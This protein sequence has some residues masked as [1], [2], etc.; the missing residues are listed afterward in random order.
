MK[1]IIS[2]FGPLHLVK[3]AVVLSK[4]VDV[5]VIQGYIPNRWNKW[6]LHLLSRILKRDMIKAF[7]K[8]TPATLDGNNYSVFF[9]EL[10]RFFVHYLGIE[11]KLKLGY[12]THVMYGFFSRR[13]INKSEIFHVRSGSGLGG[14]IDKARRLGM[15]VIVDH[16][17]AHP[18]F[19]EKQLRDEYYR[20]KQLFDMGMD[21][22][23]WQGILRDCEKAD[24]LLVNSQFVKDTFCEYGYPQDKIK[25]VYLGVR[26]DFQY[27]KKTYELNN[28]ILRILFTGGFSFRKGA[29]Y[30]IEALKELDHRGMPYQM[31]VVGDYNE[32]KGLI[33][34]YCPRHLNLV[35]VVPQDDLKQYLSTSDVYLFPSLCEGCASSGMEA[36][37]AGLPVITTKESGLPIKHN[38]NGF[39]VK[40]K[41][42][43]SIIDAL[44]FIYRDKSLRERI[45]QNAAKL[46]SKNYTWELYAKRVNS[47]YEE[48][49]KD[50]IKGNKL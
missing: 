37:A 46:I 21:S 28:G 8:R 33:A 20:N 29:E 4:L 48:M 6:L 35:G 22:T 13:Y 3:S 23:R 45:G 42:A 43:W 9:P 31:T 1:V 2:T 41:D 36:M 11:N 5:K 7:Q 14:A 40:T 44:Y 25:I 10:C 18:A 27:L 50:S 12:Y 26:K 38:V 16:S 32:V 47:I 30:V 17:I 15:K 24:V 49:I 19:M 34:E 39:I